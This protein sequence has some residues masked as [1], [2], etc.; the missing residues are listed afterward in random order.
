MSVVAL[1]FAA[2]GGSPPLPLAGLSVLIVEDSESAAE[3]LGLMA[4]AGGARVRRADGLAA[5]E[6]HLMSWRPDV[7]IV[8]PGLPDGDGLELVARMAAAGFRKPRIVVLS[9]QD[10]VAGA[11]RAAGADLCLAKPL[12]SSGALHAALAGMP[13]E[14]DGEWTAPATGTMQDDIARAR[15]RLL[16]ALIT[17][18]E[19]S[20]RYALQFLV[21]LARQSGAPALASVA[22]IDL[23]TDDPLALGREVATH[24]RQSAV[25]Q[26]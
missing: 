19:D 12:A 18:R 8:D 6:R 21:S 16:E 1:P 11:A 26:I 25:H 13:M 4:R 5:A 15:L 7:V 17:R 23:A 14:D 9:G 24:L 20:V 3:A 2:E 10:D 22:G